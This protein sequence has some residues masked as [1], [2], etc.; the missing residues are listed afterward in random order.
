MN[1]TKNN[2]IGD[3][4]KKGATES[5]PILLDNLILNHAKQSCKTKTSI[6]NPTRRL[7]YPVA[8]AAVLI[9]GLSVIFNLQNINQEI[10]S[11]PQTIEHNKDL[12]DAIMPTSFKTHQSEKQAHRLKET[13]EPHKLNKS[14]PKAFLI[15][16]SKEET[17]IPVESTP[18]L[19][20]LEISATKA[21]D[22]NINE[23][24][25][26]ASGSKS[27]KDE[28]EKQDDRKLAF[29]DSTEAIATPQRS[30]DRQ[31][32]DELERVIVT[33]SRIRSENL[34]TENISKD[35][36]KLEQLI[37]QKKIAKAKRYLKL[38]KDKHPNYDFSEHEKLIIK[39]KK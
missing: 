14:K 19:E 3:L 11:I 8:T 9:L 5:T 20:S 35:L 7:A 31:Q 39:L 23:S 30:E 32:Q 21:P 18:L 10:Q 24:L 25:G 37:R 6:P 36:Q 38:L 16:E 2:S 12:E 13:K 17:T 1:T 4:Y 15:N 28:L 26:F 29:V 34:K 27:Q 33:R 22:Y